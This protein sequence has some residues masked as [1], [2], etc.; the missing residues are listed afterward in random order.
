M[1]PAHFLALASPMMYWNAWSIRPPLQ[2]WLPSAPE[3]STSCCSDSD[4]SLLVAMNMAP[5]TEP[6][7]EKAQHEPHWPWF[8]MGV[9]A[10]LDDQSTDAG[11]ACTPSRD[12]STWR[13]SCSRER[14]PDAK[15]ALNSSAVRSANWFTPMRQLWPA[16]LWPSIL[17]TL[18]AKTLLRGGGGEDEVAR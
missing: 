2:P 7:V 11:L 1:R 10:P 6:V 5:S 4:G 14:R 15:R 18:A 9:T 8:L 16:A 12:V 3:Q 17:R 13:G